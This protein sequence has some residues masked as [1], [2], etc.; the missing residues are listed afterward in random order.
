[1]AINI[2]AARL[3]GGGQAGMFVAPKGPWTHFS[4]MHMH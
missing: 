3:V 1:V 4:L 2:A